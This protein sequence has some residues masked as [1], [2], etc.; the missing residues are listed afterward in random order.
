MS[1]MQQVNRKKLDFISVTNTA[2]G[3]LLAGKEQMVALEDEAMVWGI[4]RLRN[5]SGVERA[6]VEGLKLYEMDDESYLEVA[7]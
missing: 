2:P 3:R 5:L 7:P 1:I 4:P 6:E